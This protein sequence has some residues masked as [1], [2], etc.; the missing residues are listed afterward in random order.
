MLYEILIY[1][2]HECVKLLN[3]HDICHLLYIQGQNYIT[4]L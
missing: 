2:F 3:H 4:I 1:E